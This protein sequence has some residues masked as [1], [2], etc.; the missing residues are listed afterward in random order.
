MPLKAL[1]KIREERV[2]L[3]KPKNKEERSAKNA[4]NFLFIKQLVKNPKALG[5]IV[6]SSEALGKFISKQIDVNAEG[7]FVEVGAGT[8]ALTHELLKAGVH[9]E[10]LF[11]VELE[12]NLSAFLK[13]SLPP[14]VHVIT[15]DASHLETLLPP[16]VLGH[17]EAIISG[18][19][20]MNLSVFEQLGIIRSCFSV[21]REGGSFLQFTYG[22]LSPLPAKKLG[23]AKKRMGHVFL[24]FPPATVWRYMKDE[25]EVAG[26][27]QDA[28]AAGK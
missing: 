9:P 12:E 14:Q 6:P 25:K 22:P 7:C 10:K 11:V 5:S 24:N 21:M 20:M 27:M 28:K 26:L 17:V 4:E 3:K 2:S 19:P 23:L 13:K 18:I 16:H 8:G 1:K 15:G